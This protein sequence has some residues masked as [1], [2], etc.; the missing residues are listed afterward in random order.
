MSGEMPLSLVIREPAVVVGVL[1]PPDAKGQ[2]QG[3]SVGC[4]AHRRTHLAG[5]LPGEERSHLF[6]VPGRPSPGCVDRFSD[7][8][9]LLLV[10]ADFDGRTS[11][12]RASL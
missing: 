7:L 2:V 11:N 9:I 12:D 3:F 6:P 10:V 1:L 5:G 8:P 4:V